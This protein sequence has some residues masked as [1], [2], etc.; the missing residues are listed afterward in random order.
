[1][2]SSTSSSEPGATRSRRCRW[3][4]ALLAAAVVVLAIELLV[5]VRPRPARKDLVR[6]RLY[7]PNVMPGVAGSVVQWQVAHATLLKEQQDLLLLGDS[8]CLSGLEAKLLMER[9]GLKTW[10]LGTFGFIYTTGQADI[11]WLFIERN[12][13]PRFLVYNTSHYSLTA[14]R[15]KRAVRTWVSRLREWMAPPETVRYLLPSMR[16][17]QELRNIILAIGKESVPYTG[18]DLP[19]GRFGSD[20]EIRC[21]LWENRGSL[22]DPLEVDLE[23]VLGENLVWKPR[24]HPDCVDGLKRMFEMA[25]EHGFPILILFN[26]LPEQADNEIVREAMAALEGALREAI[27]PYPGVSIY[28][29]FLRFY[30]N[31]FCIDMRHV[32]VLGARRNTEELAEWIRAHWL[33]RS[34]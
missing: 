3:P 11:L 34:D 19:R 23:E 4:T 28:Q 30:P 20:H 31:D 1:M 8:A 25:R 27:L 7:N 9:T 15:G 24:F 16:H 29:P 18:L 17:R 12:G 5:A 33:D 26:P 13:P 2:I 21:R 6:H 10:N 22:P 14:G 32:N